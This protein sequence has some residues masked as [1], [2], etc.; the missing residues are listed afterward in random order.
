MESLLFASISGSAPF[1]SDIYRGSSAVARPDIWTLE[2]S[3]T[4]RSQLSADPTL[5]FQPARFESREAEFGLGGNGLD[6]FPSLSALGGI[7]G[8]AA[9][10]SAASRSLGEHWGKFLG[11][12][13]AVRAPEAE[14][15]EHLAYRISEG[16]SGVSWSVVGDRVTR[17]E[18][19]SGTLFRSESEN[20]EIPDPYSYGR[21][22]DGNLHIRMGSEGRPEFARR[23]PD[24]SFAPEE[25]SLPPAR[26]EDRFKNDF[27]S[28]GNGIYM[29]REYDGSVN[30]GVRDSNGGIKVL[31]RPAEK[32]PAPLPMPVQETA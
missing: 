14:V 31:P 1:Y 21:I 29:N 6:A 13:S 28:L 32:P 30:F 25:V 20:G 12:A 27:R 2:D 5:L 3:E 7:R 24:G 19:N 11:G 26:P 4:W 10:G 23:Q 9:E 22:G 16:N 17:T 18:G 15:T 8:L